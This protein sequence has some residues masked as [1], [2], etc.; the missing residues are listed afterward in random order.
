[1][2][3]RE[4][5]CQGKTGAVNA[6]KVQRASWGTAPLLYVVHRMEVSGQIHAPA[7]LSPWK[8]PSV[9]TEYEAWWG[10]EPLDRYGE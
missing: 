10:Q 2:V 4:I 8:E 9:H 1:M 3:L 5:K 6:T 7:A